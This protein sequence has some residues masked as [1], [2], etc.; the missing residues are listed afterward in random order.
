M[1]VGG[2]VTLVLEAT[3][4]CCAGGDCW[5]LLVASIVCVGGGLHLGGGPPGRAGGGKNAGLRGSSLDGFSPSVGALRVAFFLDARKY[6][7]H[8]VLQRGRLPLGW[9]CCRGDGDVRVGL[10][11]AV[12]LRGRGTGAG[13]KLQGVRLGAAAGCGADFH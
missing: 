11:V 6:V 3:R 10:V 4:S 5:R 13:L 9:G 2:E 12:L 8:E 1:V 7:V